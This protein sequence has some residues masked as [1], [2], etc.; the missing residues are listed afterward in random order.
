MDA[1]F[2][3]QIYEVFL[4][5]RIVLTDGVLALDI[6]PAYQDRQVVTTPQALVD[7]VV[8]KTSG[9]R[10]ELLKATNEFNF[11][12]LCTIKILDIAVGSGRS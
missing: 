5:Q 12:T 7:D 3:G 1:D 2:L 11:D 6:K 4:T 9:G 8:R 10:I